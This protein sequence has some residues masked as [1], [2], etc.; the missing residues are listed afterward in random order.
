V[1]SRYLEADTDSAFITFSREAMG[2]LRDEMT[3][4]QAATGGYVV[5]AEFEA[6]GTKFLFA[7]LL[8]T[9]A[10][11]NFDDNLNLIQSPM[12]DLDHLRHGARIRYD[13]IS[14]NQDGVVLF[15]SKEAKGASDY[16]VNFIGCEEIARPEVQGRILYTAL[17]R[18]AEGQ[19]YNDDQKSQLLQGAYSYWQDCRKNNQAM[20][21][22]GISNA[23]SPNDPN[24]LLAHLG[25]EAQGLAGEFPPPSTT[26]MK[27]FI[28]FSIN[29]GGL[30][31]EFDRSVWENNV[32]INASA[33]TLT[34]TNL[35]EELVVAIK[36]ELENV[37]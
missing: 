23:L 27:R 26:V 34:I 36:R 8:G 12:L 11:P 18:W 6:D 16:F 37:S 33:K 9:T 7:A 29:K 1:L 14:G 35:T 25:A 32:R 15:I 13:K 17:Q 24:A 5:F 30:K 31:L 4:Q 19:R 2:V 21:L 20:T 28:K 22:T 3:G 10:K